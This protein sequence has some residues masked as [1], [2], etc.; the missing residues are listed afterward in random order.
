MRQLALILALLLD[1]DPTHADTT[2]A[3]SSSLGQA[4]SVTTIDQRNYAK[5]DLSRAVGTALA[6]TIYNSMQTCMGGVSAAVGAPSASVAIGASIESH[7][8]NVRQDALMVQSDPEVYKA[9]LC[10]SSR[11]EKAYKMV[12]RPCLTEPEQLTEAQAKANSEAR[13]KALTEKALMA[14]QAKKQ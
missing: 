1:I 5:T 13:M 6:P 8:C 10:Q 9:V 2:Q 4:V 14:Q 12:G 7:D 3:G 11:L